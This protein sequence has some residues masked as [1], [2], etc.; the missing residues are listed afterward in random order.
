MTSL[1]HELSSYSPAVF[2]SN[3]TAIQNELSNQT[4]TYVISEVVLDHPL[5]GGG[6]LE[7]SSINFSIDSLTANIQFLS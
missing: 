1:Q 6:V 7:L 5:G 3:Y 4:D 2:V